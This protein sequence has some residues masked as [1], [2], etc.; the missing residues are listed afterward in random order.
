MRRD[1]II[2]RSMYP[3][4]AEMRGLAQE[5]SAIVCQK[6][7]TSCVAGEGVLVGIQQPTPGPCSHKATTKEEERKDTSN[8][9]WTQRNFLSLGDVPE[10]NPCIPI[11]G[12]ALVKL[13]VSRVLCRWSWTCSLVV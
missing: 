7:H 13:I 3:T 8:W 2:L 9:Y 12:E 4:S 6:H 1:D 11:N 10:C 5:L